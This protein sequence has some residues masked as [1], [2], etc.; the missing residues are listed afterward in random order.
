M[1]FGQSLD[2]SLRV[3][4]QL[5][6]RVALV[7]IVEACPRPRPE[8]SRL[9]EALKRALGRPDLRAQARGLGVPHLFATRENLP[10]LIRFV[11][12]VRAD[13][14]AIASFP[15]L[16]PEEAIAAF[17]RGI[18]NLHPSLLPAYRGPLPVLWQ[19]YRQE[20][21]GG[22]T[23]HFIDRGEDTGDIVAQ[24]PA[25]LALDES[26]SVYL[27]RCGE[28]GGAMLAQALQ[29]IEAGR[30]QRRPQRDSPCPFRARGL[31]RGERLLDFRSLPVAQTFHALQGGDNLL[32][33]LLPE[34]AGLLRHLELAPSGYDSRR[35]ALPAGQYGWDGVR[36]FIAHA[37]GRILLRAR[38]FRA[39]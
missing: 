22:V 14:G 13:A 38:G 24:A 34:P 32:G 4:R 29:A 17:P 16:L 21:Q 6:G 5:V 25:R 9:E 26:G 7:G 20:Q 23:V 27:A 30:A 3:L 11:R 8:A 36:P 12:Q 10:D 1:L 19:Y 35:T 2:Y 37:E 33:L 15:R 31:R 28:L 39:R 18:L